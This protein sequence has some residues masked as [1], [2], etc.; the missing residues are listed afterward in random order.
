MSEGMAVESARRRFTGKRADTVL[1][2]SRATLEVLREVGYQAL[3][4]QAVASK[5]GLARATAYTYFASKEHLVAEVYWRRL[6]GQELPLDSRDNIERVVAV[7]R[8]LALLVADE[9]AFAQ[10]IRVTM[11]STDPDVEQLRL[12]I[13]RYIHDLIATALGDTADRDTVVILELIYTGAM[14]R[15]GT[16]GVSYQHVADQ[17]ET[18]ARRIL[19]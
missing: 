8:H 2:L 13:G 17:L 6:S 9:P 7:L 19:R 12:Q 18:A 3:T 16:G 4:L 10:A 1:K 11:N 5:A 14:V 15:A